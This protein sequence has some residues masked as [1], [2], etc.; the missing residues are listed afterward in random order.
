MH[1]Q[2]Q[3]VVLH[4]IYHPNI[5]GNLILRMMKQQEL[6]LNNRRL[7]YLSQSKCVQSI[8]NL[9]YIFALYSTYSKR[10]LSTCH[11]SSQYVAWIA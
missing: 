3:H 1:I 6:N 9:I 11:T 5:V 2:F 4:N 7:D 10:V 8:S